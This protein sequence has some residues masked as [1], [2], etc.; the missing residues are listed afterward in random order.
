M[1]TGKKP[2]FVN[3]LTR[4]GT[5]HTWGLPRALAE[6]SWQS[7]EEPVGRLREAWEAYD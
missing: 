4:G 6:R 7:L 3:K 2:D 1:E 5:H